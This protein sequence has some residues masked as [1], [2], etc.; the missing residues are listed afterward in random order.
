MK[1]KGL[2]LGLPVI[3]TS[4][5]HG[6]APEIAWKGEADPRSMIAAIDLAGKLAGSNH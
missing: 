2:T 4:P 6:T 1:E 3:R 5:A